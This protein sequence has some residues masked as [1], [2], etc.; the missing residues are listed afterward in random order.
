MA[1]W[2]EENPGT[3]IGPHSAIET[4]KSAAN[5]AG[6][7]RVPNTSPL[8][9]KVFRTRVVDAPRAIQRSDAHPPNNEELALA[10]NGNEANIA[11][12]PVESFLSVT[13]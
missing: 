6:K 7:M 13:R 8:T 2:F 4:R 12:I 9:T 11:I 1:Q 10:Q 5:A 3:N